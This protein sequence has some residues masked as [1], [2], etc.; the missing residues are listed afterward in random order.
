MESLHQGTD[1]KTEHALKQT[2]VCDKEGVDDEASPSDHRMEA[3]LIL[4][5]P[6]VDEVFPPHDASLL[7]MH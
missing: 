5:I 4:Q 2:K 1:D 6:H 7:A 3:S